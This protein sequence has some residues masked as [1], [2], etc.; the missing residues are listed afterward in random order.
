M[1]AA[2]YGGKSALALYQSTTLQFLPFSPMCST[3]NCLLYME[4]VDAEQSCLSGDVS[5]SLSH[6]ARE[7]TQD[8]R[9]RLNKEGR[10]GGGG[11]R[12]RKQ[13]VFIS[14]AFGGREVMAVFDHTMD[15]GGGEKA[16]CRTAYKLSYLR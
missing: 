13:K 1:I 15:N 6:L 5:H 10:G 12:V 3:S 2:L 11:W 16:V 8:G 7:G 4:G 9:C 14:R